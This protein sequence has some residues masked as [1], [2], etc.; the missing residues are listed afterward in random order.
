MDLDIVVRCPKVQ[1]DQD[2][3]KQECQDIK[4]I[5]L[6]SVDQMSIALQRVNAA[7]MAVV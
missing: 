6:Q 3:V 1:V 2:L 7:S 5:V 4:K